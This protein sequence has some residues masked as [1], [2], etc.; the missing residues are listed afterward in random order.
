MTK[1]SVSSRDMKE[2]FEEVEKLKLNH[3]EQVE[4]KVTKNNF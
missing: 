4:V 2:S 1:T 3:F